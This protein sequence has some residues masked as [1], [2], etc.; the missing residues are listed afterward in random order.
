MWFKT[1]KLYFSKSVLRCKSLP[2]ELYWHETG[3]LKRALDFFSWHYIHRPILLLSIDDLSSGIEPENGFAI[4][5][6]QML[7]LTATELGVGEASNHFQRRWSGAA[8]L[9]A[10]EL[11]L[12]KVTCLGGSKP[13]QGLLTLA[14]IAMEVRDL[15]LRGFTLWVVEHGYDLEE[16][17]MV[18]VLVTMFLSHFFKPFFLQS[19]SVAKSTRGLPC[20][21]SCNG[22][23]NP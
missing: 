12:L 5:S 19:S 18:D 13:Q 4:H 22:F 3:R 8:C 11:L 9:R 17:K 7:N 16:K 10:F 15:E 23:C 14:C 6:C 20:M 2:F 1:L 21:E